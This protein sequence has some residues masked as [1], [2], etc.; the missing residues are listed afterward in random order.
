MVEDATKL[1]QGDFN[2]ERPYERRRYPGSRRA[3]TAL[4]FQIQEDGDGAFTLGFRVLGGEEVLKRIIFMNWG[5]REHEIK[6]SG[7]WE[8]TGVR[9]GISVRLGDRSGATG[10]QGGRLAWVDENGAVVIRGS[11]W[12]PGQKSTGFLQDARDLAVENL[13]RSIAG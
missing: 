10:W 13:K 6:P 3:T 8:L 4:D 9:G 11:V 1:M 5:T 7:A 2:L 12:H